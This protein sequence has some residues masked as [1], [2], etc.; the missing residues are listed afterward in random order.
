MAE[1]EERVAPEPGGDPAGARR[2][3]QA[4]KALTARFYPKAAAAGAAGA[5]ALRETGRR[6]PQAGTAPA[7][8]LKQVEI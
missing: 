7:F 3:L 8:L 1:E 2:L 5:T 4:T 6:Q